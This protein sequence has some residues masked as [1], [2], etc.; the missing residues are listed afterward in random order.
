MSVMSDWNLD[1]VRERM[2]KLSTTVVSDALDAVG[3]RNNAVAGVRPVWD[4]PPFIN[5]LF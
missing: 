2:L 1:E 4:C 5:Q 3:I